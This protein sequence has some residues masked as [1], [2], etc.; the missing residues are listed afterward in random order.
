MAEKVDRQKK[1]RRLTVAVLGF[2]AND[3]GNPALGEQI[4]EMLVASL[5]ADDSFELVDRRTMEATLREHELA[6]TGMVPPAHAIKAG[7]LL[8]AQILVTGRAFQLGER[9]YVTGKL[10]GTE[11][12]LVKAVMVKGDEDADIG[13]LALELAEKVD[14]GI[15]KHGRALTG[16]DLVKANPVPALQAQLAKVKKKPVVAVLIREEHIARP[17]AAAARPP[18]PAVETE[19][20]RILQRAGFSIQD[21]KGNELADWVDQA[22]KKD[23]LGPWPRGLAG[24][25]LVITGEALSEFGSRLRNLV[26][27][28]ARAEINMISRKEGKIVLADRTTT[29]AV[30][31]GENVAGKTALE[32]AGHVLGGRVLEYF[33]KTIGNRK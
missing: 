4:S 27:C 12:T 30:D 1:P 8:G 17:R 32:K 6:L 24:V 10:I 16:A 9:V 28:V 13:E 3:P 26:T 19:I 21:V 25:D 18:D 11:T 31:L 23:D 29:R 22:T 14:Q 20:K 2:D 15:V 7:K 5:S 33:S